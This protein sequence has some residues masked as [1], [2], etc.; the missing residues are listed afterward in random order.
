MTGGVNERIT[1]RSSIQLKLLINPLKKGIAIFQYPYSGGV[2]TGYCY[3]VISVGAETGVVHPV[4]MLDSG[5]FLPLPVNKPPDFSGV[6][7]GGYYKVISVGTEAGAVQTV[8][9]LDGGFFLPLP[10]NKSPDFSG[11]IMGGCY[12]VISVGAEADFQLVKMPNGY[13]ILAEKNF[14]FSQYFGNGKE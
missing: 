4:S 1:F 14:R 7:T 3:K 13:Y 10:V 2:K 11:V 12:K 6:I 8:S 5:F 9:M